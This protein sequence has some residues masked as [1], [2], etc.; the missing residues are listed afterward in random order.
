MTAQAGTSE[1]TSERE[2]ERERGGGS[3]RVLGGGQKGEAHTHTHQQGLA[4]LAEK[5]KNKPCYHLTKKNIESKPI[6]GQLQKSY[7]LNGA[8]FQ[9]KLC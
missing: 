4:V 3:N 7:K 9:H 1:Q 5:K 6:T 8:F 2:R